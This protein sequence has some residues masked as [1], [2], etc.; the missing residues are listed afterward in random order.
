VQQQIADTWGVFN[1]VI[2][3]GGGRAGRASKG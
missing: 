3:A 2:Y 1:N